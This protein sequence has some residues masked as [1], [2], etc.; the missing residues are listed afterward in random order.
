MSRSLKKP[1]Y[2]AWHVQRKLQKELQP[3]AVILIYSRASVFTPEMVGLT[4]GVH[5]G[6]KHIPVHV[7]A[8]MIGHRAG[9]FSPTRSGR[10]RD[11]KGR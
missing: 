10:S 1:L 6:R 3:G 2:V 8:D 11:K 7:T 9:E 5:N 4:F